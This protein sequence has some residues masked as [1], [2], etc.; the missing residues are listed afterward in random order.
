MIV[1]T[2]CTLGVAAWIG[3]GLYVWTRVDVRI[4]GVTSGAVLRPL[5]TDSMVVDI[6]FA[7]ARDVP[8]ATVR[9]DGNE[10][11]DLESSDR[12]FRWTIEGP[13]P[14]GFHVLEVRVPRPILGPAVFRAEFTVDGTAPPLRVPEITE[15][16]AVDAEVRIPGSTEP[17]SALTLD[18]EPVEVDDDGRFEI[19]LDRP[20]YGSPM[21]LR[22]VDEAG[23]AS[24]TTI[25]TPVEYPEV[26]H[27]HVRAEDWADRQVREQILTLVD[28][29]KITAVQL[30]VKDEAG[31]VGH[32]TQV[33]HARAIGAAADLYDL[34]EA[35]ELL[36]DHGAHV[37]VRIV[38]F[39]DTKFGTDAWQRG[40]RDLVVQNTDGS[41][42][43]RGEGVFLSYAQPEVRAYLTEL[44]IEAAEMGVDDIMFDY[45]RRPDG[46]IEDMRIPGLTTSPEQG[47]I[48]FLREIRTSLRAADHDVYLGAAVFGLAAKEPRGAREIAQDVRGM[49]PWLDYVAPMIYPSHFGRGEYGIDVPNDEPGL[50]IERSLADFQALVA[51]RGTALVPWLQ[52]FSYAGRTYGHD[53]VRAQIDAACSLGVINHGLWNAV[54]S[55][56]VS[57]LGQCP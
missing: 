19:V 33:A 11:A 10:L 56:T 32:T 18:G 7:N 9:F 5:Q 50:L 31:I 44:A 16:V 24:F 4:E 15:P 57:A 47:I 26:R 28:E 55:Y 48:D 35:V 38:A 27:V 54:S 42:L 39:N 25:V 3:W 51:E 40:A 23:I 43:E 14:E 34:E 21:L 36:Q 37:I 29:R 20:H 52:D 1:A 53:E 13:L 49:A 12:G 46:A 30:D 41:M 45:I 2:F 8:H 17:G 6:T 22:A